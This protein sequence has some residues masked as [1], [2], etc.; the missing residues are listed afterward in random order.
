MIFRNSRL[1]YVIIFQRIANGDIGKHGNLAL[2]SVEEEPRHPG[3]SLR[4]RHCM[5]EESV[6]E[7]TPELKLA[8]QWN[9]PQVV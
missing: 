8:T 3:G 1:K 4:K 5:R 2:K 6:R 9:V 7:K